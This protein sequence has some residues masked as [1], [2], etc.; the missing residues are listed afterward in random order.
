[1]RRLTAS[2]LALALAGCSAPGG[3]VPTRPRGTLTAPSARPSPTAAE[4]PTGRID[5]L[6]RD[7]EVVPGEPYHPGYDRSCGPGHACVFGPLWSDAHPGPAGHNGCDTRQDALLAQLRQV[8]LRWGSSCRV[9]DGVLVDPYSGAR[10]TWRRDGYWIQIDHVFPLARAW[11]A[12]AWAWSRR[13]RLRFAN[14]V[15]RE[16]LAVSARANQ[17]K[18]AGGLAEWLPPVG[19]LRCRYVAKYLTVAAAYGLPVTEAD[20]AAARRVAAHC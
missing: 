15:D 12:G 11:H 16:L 18:G 3:D 19:A 14:D 20:A 7:L 9:Y 17:E 5:R 4:G 6:L 1:M 13:R 10:L 2:A 8:Q